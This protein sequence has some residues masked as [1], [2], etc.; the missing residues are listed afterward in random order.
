MRRLAVAGVHA[1][2]LDTAAARSLAQRAGAAARRRP[3][4]VAETLRPA[5]EATLLG[6]W[7]CGGRR[8]RGRI[9]WFLGEGRGAR[10]LSSGDDVVAAGV[11]R[12]PRVAQVL[13][14]LR[15]LRLDGRV[16]TKDDERAAVA[17]WILALTRKGESR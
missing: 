16:R 17:D 12:G 15:D 7:L 9:E 13:G 6:A 3:S 5:R 4:Q 10:P 8:A 2:Q 11:P 14:V 1:A